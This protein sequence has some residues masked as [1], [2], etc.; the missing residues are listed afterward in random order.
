MITF[1]DTNDGFLVDYEGETNTYCKV[2]KSYINPYVLVD[3]LID[4][5]VEAE[6]VCELTRKDG[7]KLTEVTK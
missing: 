4:M 5:G 2:M 3:I 1:R 6:M 7:T